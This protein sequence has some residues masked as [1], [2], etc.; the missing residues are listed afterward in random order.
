M[1]TLIIYDNEGYIVDSVTGAYKKPAGL[2]YLEV[3]IPEGKRIKIDGIGI[4]VSVTPHQAILED[5][6]P[7][8]ID[9]LK[10]DTSTIAEITATVVEDNASI[11]N[12]LATVLLEIENMK[13]DI[14]ALKGA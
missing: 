8:E 12:T 14:S 7:T 6:P 10:D 13:A 1:Q 3:E 9:V 4:D 2:P 11:A 5:I